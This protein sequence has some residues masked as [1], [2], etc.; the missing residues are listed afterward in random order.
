M[1][2]Q[3]V[4]HHLMTEVNPLHE[5]VVGQLFWLDH[6]YK[7]LPSI[8]LSP[9]SATFSQTVVV[10][11]HTNRLCVL[12]VDKHKFILLGHMELMSPQWLPVLPRHYSCRQ[13]L[14]A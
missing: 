10:G 12:P 2:D 1:L 14:L 11:Q 7:L 8:Q 3:I 6:I 4:L 9:D 13:L 5:L